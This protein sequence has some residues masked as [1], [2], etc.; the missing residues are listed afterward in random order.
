MVK[1]KRDSSGQE[2]KSEGKVEE[3]KAERTV[4]K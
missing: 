3:W 1:I 2:A 4:M